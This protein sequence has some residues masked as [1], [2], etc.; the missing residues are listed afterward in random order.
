MKRTIYSVPPWRIEQ[1]PTMAGNDQ[2]VRFHK[3]NG[4]RKL[5]DQIARWGSAGWDGARWIPKP[6][7]VPAQLLAFVENHMLEH[8]P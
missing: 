2:L 1:D 4:Q 3:H 5:L 7:Q 6:P 8:C